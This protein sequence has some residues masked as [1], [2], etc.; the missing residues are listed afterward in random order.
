MDLL[1]HRG[2]LIDVG[3][4]FL[5][6][7]QLKATIDSLTYAKLNVLHWHLTEDLSSITNDHQRILWLQRSLM[8]KKP[9]GFNGFMLYILLIIALYDPS[10]V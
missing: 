4:N 5:P 8:E 3:R 7:I 1:R 2:L 9:Y 6:V 10:F